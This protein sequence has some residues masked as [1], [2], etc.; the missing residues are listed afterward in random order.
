MLM[1]FIKFKLF[2]NHSNHYA[3]DNYDGKLLLHWILWIQHQFYKTCV[4]TIF[5]FS[6]FFMVIIMSLINMIYNEVFFSTKKSYFNKLNSFEAHRMCKQ[7][8]EYGL[9]QIGNKYIIQSLDYCFLFQMYTSFWNYYSLDTEIGVEDIHYRLLSD[10]ITGYFGNGG[11]TVGNNI[12][13]KMHFRKYCR[14]PSQQ[15]CDVL[16]NIVYLEQNGLI[17]IGNYSVLKNI[18]LYVDQRALHGIDDA[19]K[20]IND[21]KAKSKNVTSMLLLIL[22]IYKKKN[23]VNFIISFIF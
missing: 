19:S 13:W 2:I 11:K 3:S 6:R 1:L 15:D 8:V 5:C 17:G 18:F 10:L 12:R 20:L 14:L 16:Q 4:C 9:Y 21:I 23:S 7:N 22:Y